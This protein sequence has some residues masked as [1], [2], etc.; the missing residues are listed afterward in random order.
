M[1]QKIIDAELTSVAIIEPSPI[2]CY[3]M[4]GL[5][6]SFGQRYKISEFSTTRDYLKCHAK[7]HVDIVIIGLGDCSEKTAITSIRQVRSRDPFVKIIVLDCICSVE[8]ISCYFREKAN[9][10]LPENCSL[11]GFEECL[12]KIRSGNLYVTYETS[13][14]ILAYNL[15]VQM[16]VSRSQ[17]RRI[18][19]ETRLTEH[20]IQ[21]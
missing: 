5:L 3:G 9:A 6:E 21:C 13:Q 8:R 4:K 7:G 1:H 20:E 14:Q 15:K 19:F 16:P 12:I 18:H 10:Y 11:S 2:L 17:G